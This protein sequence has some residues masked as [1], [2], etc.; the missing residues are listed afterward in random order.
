MPIFIS[1][2][3]LC[4]KQLFENFQLCLSWKFQIE[5]IHRTKFRAFRHF[6]IERDNVKFVI[7][8]VHNGICIVIHVKNIQKKLFLSNKAMAL[9]GR[10]RF[11]AFKKLVTIE[12][13]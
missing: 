11:Y 2:K 7:T 3:K 4:N 12:M 6:Y 5:A 13:Y 1:T 10:I 9:K 8:K